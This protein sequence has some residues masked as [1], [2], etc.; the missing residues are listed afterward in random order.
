MAA[1]H[2]AEPLTNEAVPDRTRFVGKL[3][4]SLAFLI[5]LGGAVIFMRGGDAEQLVLNPA[6]SMAVQPVQLG[7]VQQLLQPARARNFLQP[8]KASKSP[9]ELLDIV[10]PVTKREMMGGVAASIAA[11]ASGV[12]HAEGKARGFDSAQAKNI[13]P[14]PRVGLTAVKRGPVRSG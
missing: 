12:A 1:A 14:R 2:L 7:R 13:S 6:T 8:L 4:P 9:S 10:I 5:G 11:A 3:I